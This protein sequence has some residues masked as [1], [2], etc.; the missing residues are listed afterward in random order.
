VGNPGA[1]ALDAQKK[2]LH[3]AE[4]NREDVAKARGVWRESQSA[5]NSGRLIFIDETWA[6]TNMV[7]PRGRSER[8]TRLIDTTPQGHWKTSTFIA[9]LTEDGLVA[10]GVFD[11]AINGE[12]FLAYIE[13]ILVPTL[14]AGDIVIMENLSSHKLDFPHF[15]SVGRQVITQ[16]IS[17]W[18]MKRNASSS[19]RT[20]R[21]N[22]PVE[23]HRSFQSDQ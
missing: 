19:D 14:K 15:S 3:A 10:P 9:A 5:L 11:G 18:A 16:K 20:V 4:Q 7:R 17:S 2:T 13:Q 6:K 22:G 12:L 21:P 23:A 1:V 8:G